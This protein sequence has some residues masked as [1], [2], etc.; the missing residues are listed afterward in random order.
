M[1]KDS[2]FSNISYNIWESCNDWRK[3]NWIVSTGERDKLKG[4]INEKSQFIAGNIGPYKIF[5]IN[6]IS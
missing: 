1:K 5:L 6:Y 3:A 4:H 2:S